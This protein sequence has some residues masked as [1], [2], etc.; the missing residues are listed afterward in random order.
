MARRRSMYARRRKIN[1]G[2]ILLLVLVLA[3]IVVLVSFLFRKNDYMTVIDEALDS[4]TAKITGTVN[5]VSDVDITVYSNEGIRYAN[6]HEGIKKLDSFDGTIS[7]DSEKTERVRMLFESLLKLNQTSGTED[8]PL[9]DD[10]YYWIDADFSVGEKSL[11][12]GND[13][14]NFDLYYDIESKVVYVK[15]KYYSEFSKKNNKQKLI[16]YQ[17]DDEFVRMIEELTK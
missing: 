6:Q 12:G 10:G 4:G 8:L 9:T 13:V 17:A 1:Y 11:F 3:A 2:R 7:D 14:Y 16:G 5:H 15:E